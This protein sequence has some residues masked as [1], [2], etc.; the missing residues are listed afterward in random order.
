M[1]EL[2]KIDV[3]KDGKLNLKDKH[4]SLTIDDQSLNWQKKGY[5]LVIK[6]FLPENSI[7]IMD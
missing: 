4:I 7:C 6:I 1:A 5:D 3:L 2:A